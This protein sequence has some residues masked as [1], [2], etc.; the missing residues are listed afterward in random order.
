M[1]SVILFLLL[2][3]PF[4]LV[5]FKFRAFKISRL[6]FALVTIFAV[7]LAAAGQNNITIWVPLMF[8]MIAIGA[9]C[10]AL[11]IGE[12][13]RWTFTF[14]PFFAILSIPYFLLKAKPS[15]QKI[16]LYAAEGNIDRLKELIAKGQDVDS[17]DYRGATPLFYAARNGKA[18]AVTLLLQNGA[19]TTLQLS[20]GSTAE[21]IAAKNGHLHVAEML[22]LYSIRRSG[23]SSP[24]VRSV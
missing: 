18:D 20:G 16:F 19:N 22:R 23:N 1:A 11:H 13:W 6:P 15:I 12:T 21:D 3:L 14:L 7:V 17:V 10:N 8:L 5:V 24:I 2:G 4:A 9:R